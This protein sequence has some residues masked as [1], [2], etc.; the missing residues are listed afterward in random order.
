VPFFT[1]RAI[2]QSGRYSQGRIDA[3]DPSSARRKLRQMGL[4]PVSLSAVKVNS[5]LSGTSKKAVAAPRKKIDVTKMK[6]GRAKADAVSLAF[7][8]KLYELIKSGLPLGDAI[9]SLNQRLTDPVL[10]GIAEVIWR[11]LS[12]GGT[13]GEAIRR[14]PHLFDPSLSAMIEVGE[15]TGNL[16]PIL[17][18]IVNLLRS[19]IALRKNI[20]AGLSYPIFILFIVFCVLLFV[21]FYLM[22]R[23]QEMLDSMGA[24]LSFSAWL[25]TFLAGASLTYG[26]FLLFGFGIL[27][28]L[29]QKWRKT[30]E[31]KLKSDQILLKI[32]IVKDVVL[33]A[34]LSRFSNLAAILMGSGVDATDALKL[35]EKGFKNEE[36]KQRFHISRGMINDGASFAEAFQDQG[37]LIEMDADVLSIS[38]NTGSLVN[39]FNSIY[40]TRHENLESQMKKLTVVLSTGSIF[41]VFILIFL[42]VFGVVSSIMQ[43]STTIIGA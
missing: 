24:D 39:G 31:G 37:L 40:R 21:L 8:E 35:L 12:E 42:L 16:S 36:L 19:K 25:V 15:A 32:P 13:L 18:N 9:K 20:M 23:I 3:S 34:E 28:L 26:P 30:D 6:L 38:E 29:L 33:N 4:N 27:A 43:L 14:Q 2:E 5:N 10:S 22:P 1:Y 17:E 41:F 11:D 7:L